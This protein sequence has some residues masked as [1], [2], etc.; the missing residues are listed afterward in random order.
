MRPYLEKT[1]HTKKGLVEWLKVEALSSKK[2]KA[3]CLPL[4][5]LGLLPCSVSRVIQFVGRV[6]TLA[7]QLTVLTLI[8]A[9]LLLCVPGAEVQALRA[10]IHSASQQPW[11]MAATPAILPT[12]NGTLQHMK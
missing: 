6:F 3:Y 2:K 9:E 5:L 12:M 1:H 4:C 7:R 10:C 8:L 11:D